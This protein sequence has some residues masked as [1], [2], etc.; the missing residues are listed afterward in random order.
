MPNASR[1]AAPA[2]TRRQFLGLAAA[3]PAL[4]ALPDAEAASPAASPAGVPDAPVWDDTDRAVLAAVL[5]AV[6]GPGSERCDAVAALEQSL[7]WIDDERRPLIAALP[8]LFDQASRVLVPTFAAFR[9]LTPEAQ[10]AAVGDW[11][12]S[13]LALRRQIYG[14]LRQ[15]LLAHAY[16]DPA[17]WDAIGYPGPWLG[18]IELP[19]HP[20]RFGSPAE[21][22]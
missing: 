15:L 2:A 10:R 21:L 14:G 12:A 17:T 16:A 5:A 18:R 20:L 19:V 7:A 8:M 13:P 22:P 11:A 3:L 9:N 4:L 6:Y 1:S